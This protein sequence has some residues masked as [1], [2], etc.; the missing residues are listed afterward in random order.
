MDQSLQ[1]AAS[2]ILLIVSMHC[3]SPGDIKFLKT[4]I[5]LFF[6]MWFDFVHDVNDKHE[7]ALLA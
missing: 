1:D 3:C 6:G 2:R 4:D 5:F 7:I